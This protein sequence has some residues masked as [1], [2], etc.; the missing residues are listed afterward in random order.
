MSTCN[1]LDTALK[2]LV[3][4]KTILERQYIASHVADDGGVASSS[5]PFKTW[6]EDLVEDTAVSTVRNL[7]VKDCFACF[8]EAGSFAEFWHV[9]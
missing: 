4:H 6:L 1:G 9:L 5:I 8:A 7:E 2:E 3:N